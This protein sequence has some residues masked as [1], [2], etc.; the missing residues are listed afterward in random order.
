[1]NI[2]T[3]KSVVIGGGIAGL[4]VA[5]VLRRA[6]AEVRVLEQAPEI[7]EVGAGLQISPNGFV[8]LEKLGLGNALRAKSVRG[9]AVRLRDY[10]GHDVVRLDLA[11]LP[12][13]DYHFVHRAD[14][15]D[16][17]ERAARNAGVEI[18]LGQQVASLHTGQGASATLG[19]GAVVEADLLVGADGLQS[20]AR[21]A[22]NGTV[23]PFFTRQVAWR[24]LVAE[25]GAEPEAQVFMGPHRHLVTYPLRGGRLRNIVAVQERANWHE[26]SWHTE[27]TPENLRAAFEDFCPDAFAL[28][29]RVERVHRWGLFRHPVAGKWFDGGVVLL[30]DAAHPTLPF[31]AQGANMALEDAFALGRCLQ[32]GEDLNR[33]LAAYQQMR[34]GRVRRVVETASGNAWKYHLSFPPLRLAAHTALRLGGALLPGRVVGQFDW[35][36]GYDVT[37]EEIQSVS[38]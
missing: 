30:G 28:L 38:R 15:V 34:A 18:A 9:Q 13:G 1:M 3:L 25:T 16:I 36:Y 26:E 6:G 11:R 14:L 5:L 33:A 17:L 21:Q 22:L 8:V 24:A 32:E 31:M 20:R 23:A 10:K 12:C 7:G 37:T 35:I 2:T 19:D 29:E 4:A 27:D